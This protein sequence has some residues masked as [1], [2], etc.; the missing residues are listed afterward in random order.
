[1]WDSMEKMELPTLLHMTNWVISPLKCSQSHRIP[2]VVILK[3]NNNNKPVISLIC[4]GRVCT[5]KYT[6]GEWEE[7]FLRK[8]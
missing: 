6:K 8:F 1:M 3:N 7:H 2:E 4:G 5:S